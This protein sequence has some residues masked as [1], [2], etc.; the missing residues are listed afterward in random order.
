MGGGEA[1]LLDIAAYG[2]Y[3]FTGVCLSIISRLL[4]SHCYYF[5]LPWTSI[6]MG[7]F[8]VKTM[9][10]VL[11]TEMRSYDRHSSR[12]HYLLLFMAIAQIPLFFWLGNIGA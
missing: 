10:R 1:P 11:F 2:G 3:L 6:C 5:L 4:W 12:Q 8:L 9:K 7:M